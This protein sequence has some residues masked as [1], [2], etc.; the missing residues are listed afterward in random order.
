MGVEKVPQSRLGYAY[1]VIA[2][3]YKDKKFI[4]LKSYYKL[5]TPSENCPIFVCAQRKCLRNSIDIG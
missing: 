1:Y 5:K 2:R 3:F 4:A